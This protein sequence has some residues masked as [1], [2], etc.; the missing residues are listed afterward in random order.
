MDIQRDQ[1]AREH[2]HDGT[3]D[4]ARS[5]RS[6]WR[7][8]RSADGLRGQL[9]RA[10]VM[11][12]ALAV[13]AGSTAGAVTLVAQTVSLSA[14][15]AEGD[16]SAEDGGTEGDAGTTEGDASVEDGGTEE[17]DVT[18]TTGPSTGSDE[19]DGSGSSSEDDA[20][21]GTD[22]DE[23]PVDAPLTFARAVELHG[24]PDYATILT[25]RYAGALWSLN[26][27]D[28]VNGLT[29]NSSG[30]RPTRAE[31]DALWPSVATELAEER[32]E[33]EAAEAASAAERKAELEA[34]RGDPDVQA[35]LDSFDPRII[36]GPSPDYAAILTRR[37]PGAQWS[38]NGNDPAGGLVWHSSGPKPTKSQL[39]AMWA[40]VAREMALEMDPKELARWA[41]TGD[42]IYVDGVLRP[43]G[44]VG[45]A[46][47][48]QPE[49]PAITEDNWRY[50]PGLPNTNDGSPVDSIEIY[51]DPTGGKNFEQEYG[52][53]LSRLV[54]L[55]SEAHGNWEG[56]YGSLG[57]GVVENRGLRTVQWYSSRVDRAIVVNVLTSLGAL[58]ADRSAT[59]G[60]E[61]DGEGDTDDSETNDT[62]NGQTDEGDTGIDDGDGEPDDGTDADNDDGDNGDGQTDEG[63]TETDNG[64]GEPD[65]GDVQTDEADED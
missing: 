21:D 34:R 65:D 16:A 8:L 26:G 49:P 25:R 44:W 53:D 43:Q 5:V 36:W 56:Q 22:S 50:L 38:L 32:A 35:L 27:N 63:E 52:I 3:D 45:G 14:G 19:A 40:D 7:R 15:T 12:V 30:P 51:R 24:A 6:V 9:A 57:L 64:D 39:D 29:W 33:R 61:T 46:N 58:P 10:A 28:V 62:N 11:S 20:D 54:R 18:G 60:N 41:G 37:F 1:D 47:D 59:D 13:V 55:V 42:E 2:D 4:T 48:P 17:S 31:L 23:P